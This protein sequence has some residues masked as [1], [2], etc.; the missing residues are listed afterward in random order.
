MKMRP[1]AGELTKAALLR[2]LDI[3]RRLG[4]LDVPGLGE[5]RHGKPATI[6]KGPYKVG[7]LP[8]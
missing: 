4:Y 3:A 5:M 6:R 7:E 8:R 2:N 1:A